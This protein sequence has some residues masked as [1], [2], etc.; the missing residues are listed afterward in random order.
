MWLVD[1]E[2]AT[3]D[4]QPAELLAL[5]FDC[6]AGPAVAELHGESPTGLLPF[7]LLRPFLSRTAARRHSLSSPT[8]VPTDRPRTSGNSASSPRRR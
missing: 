5:V 7:Y 8:A 6:T 4:P 3:R 1:P 2:R